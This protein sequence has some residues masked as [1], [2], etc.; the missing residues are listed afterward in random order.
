MKKNESTKIKQILSNIGCLVY[1]LIGIVQIVAIFAGFKAWWGWNTFFAALGA[2]FVG[3]I[4]ILGTIL[5]IM[6]AIKGW[7]WS[8]FSAIM[9]FCWPLALYAFIFLLGGAAEMHEKARHIWK[10]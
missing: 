4:P 2:I 1:F 3:E 9:L 7:G 5:G 6:G 8:T 10:K